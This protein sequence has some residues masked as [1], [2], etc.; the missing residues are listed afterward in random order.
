MVLDNECTRVNAETF[1]CEKGMFKVIF[2]APNVTSLLQPMDQSMLEAVKR[3]YRKRL[4][5]KIL[6]DEF[7]HSITMQID[8]K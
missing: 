8:L 7:E 1:E 2:L 4:F 6:L 3:L 5:R